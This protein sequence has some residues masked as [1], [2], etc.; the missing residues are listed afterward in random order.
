MRNFLRHV[1]SAPIDEGAAAFGAEADIDIDSIPAG[2]ATPGAHNEGG[3]RGD[4]ALFDDSPAP[5]ADAPV[6]DEQGRFARKTVEEEFPEDRGDNPADPNS[7][8]A[9]AKDEPEAKDEPKGKDKSEDKPEGKTED[10]SGT[11][12]EPEPEPEPEQKLDDKGRPIPNMVPRSRMQKEAERRRAAEHLL[13]QQNRSRALTSELVDLQASYDK[14]ES[15][16]IEAMKA[17]DFDLL[18]QI[19]KDMRAIQEAMATKRAESIADERAREQLENLKFEELLTNLRSTH[20]VL[21]DN[22]ADAFDQGT[23]D[24]INELF[25]SLSPKY[26][27]VIAMTR[28]VEYVLGV[29]QAAAVKPLGQQ[30]PQDRARQERRKEAVSRAT[31]AVSNQPKSPAVAPPAAA[32][33][34]VRTPQTLKDIES[35]SEAE[36]AKAR[37]DFDYA[38]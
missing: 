4:A 30:T 15:R 22:N 7:A 35:M 32:S 29:E 33:A 23:V 1:L 12:Q 21:D 9:K 16:E 13:E 31:A 25:Q 17:N 5:K 34:L 2:D 10:K 3:D 18:P 36:Q 20:A 26:G 37:G 24:E 11:E 28:A 38:E 14:L 27:K 6:R 8:E 19:R